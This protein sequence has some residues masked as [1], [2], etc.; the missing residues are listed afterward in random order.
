MWWSKHFTARRESHTQATLQKVVDT[1][2]AS[3]GFQ[4]PLSLGSGSYGALTVQ[5]VR[6]IS[7][8]LRPS[9]TKWHFPR[10]LK[11]PLCCFFLLL[12]FHFCFVLITFTVQSLLI[13][14]F[15]MSRILIAF[16]KIPASWFHSSSVLASQTSCIM[17]LQV[18]ILA[19]LGLTI[20][21]QINR[22][23]IFSS[24][25]FVTAHTL[26]EN[27]GYALIATKDQEVYGLHSNWV[28]TLRRR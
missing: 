20:A 11:S 9:I 23:E 25:S 12:F 24:I 28:G 15:L 18:G 22:Y 17:M 2:D 3:G 26:R 21:L 5:S 13:A 8:I 27:V 14:L 4:C 6:Q 7:T 16:L 19:P 10:E 1:R